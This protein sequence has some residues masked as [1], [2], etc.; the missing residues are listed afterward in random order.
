MTPHH[1]RVKR[2]LMSDIKAHQPPSHRQQQWSADISKPKNRLGPLENTDLSSWRTA[3]N[4]TFKKPKPDLLPTSLKKGNYKT[5]LSHIIF[6]LFFLFFFLF[7]IIFFFLINTLF[8]NGKATAFSHLHFIGFLYF[9][10]L[11]VFL[12][13]ILFPFLFP[14]LF[15]IFLEKCRYRT[16]IEL[17]NQNQKNSLFFVKNTG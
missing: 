17:C 9:F 15:Q 6:L 2:K 8:Y 13:L 10:P 3:Q 1:I 4:S 5:I 16:S 11:F 7:Q 14:H 12:L